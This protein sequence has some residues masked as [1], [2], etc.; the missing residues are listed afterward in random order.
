LKTHLDLITQHLT[1]CG[2]RFQVSIPVKDANSLSAAFSQ[3]DLSGERNNCFQA[4]GASAASS[5]VSTFSAPL[6][7]LPSR[8]GTFQ[9]RG[10][11]RA[12]R[13]DVVDAGVERE[14][15]AL[16]QGRQGVER[17]LGR[18]GESGCLDCEGDTLLGIV[19]IAV[20]GK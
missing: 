20:A 9:E 1:G 2:T 4:L 13:V 15:D 10:K 3:R 5:E 19:G 18:D 11:H 16:E 7:Q 6:A 8:S 12:I 14:Q 17:G